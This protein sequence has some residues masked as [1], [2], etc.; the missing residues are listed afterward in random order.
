MRGFIKIAGNLLILLLLMVHLLVIS[1]LMAPAPKLLGM[2]F[3]DE[4]DYIRAS[5]VPKEVQTFITRNKIEIQGDY[6]AADGAF[7]RL[8]FRLLR[9]QRD[10]FMNSSEQ[11]A[12]DMNLLNFGKG[13]I[14]LSEAAQFFYKKPIV[15][16]SDPEWLTLINLQKIFSKK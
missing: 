5:D 11:L 15:K 9:V 2:V 4:S 10:R 1:L 8:I 13:V 6:R 3:G 7:G 12:L 16:L 14:G